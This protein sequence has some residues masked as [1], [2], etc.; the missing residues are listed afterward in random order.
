MSWHV[1][2]FGVFFEDSAVIF[3]LI[4]EPQQLKMDSIEQALLHVLEPLHGYILLAEKLLSGAAQFATAFNFGP[5]D[6]DAWPVER[7][8]LFVAEIW[9]E[10]ASWVRETGPS[11]HDAQRFGNAILCVKSPIRT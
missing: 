1:D 5:R 9:G 8:A 10:N 4:Q 2:A 11:V 7:I 6:E 3:T